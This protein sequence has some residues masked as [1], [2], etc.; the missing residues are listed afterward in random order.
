MLEAE[1]ELGLKF[2]FTQSENIMSLLY[3]GHH[4]EER[5][6]WDMNSTIKEIAVPL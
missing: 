5:D 1:I 3:E 4:G 6:Q 2:L